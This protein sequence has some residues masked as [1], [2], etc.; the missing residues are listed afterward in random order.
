MVTIRIT[1]TTQE[2][3]EAFDTPR[4]YYNF[5]KKLTNNLIFHGLMNLM[6]LNGYKNKKG[7]MKNSDQNKLFGIRINYSE[8]E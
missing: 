5:M 4:G 3:K 7:M 8:L 6:F 1:V 2:I